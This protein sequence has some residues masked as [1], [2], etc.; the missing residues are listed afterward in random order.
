MSRG[1]LIVL[2]GIDGAGKS[3]LQQVLAKRLRREGHQVLLTR[4][5]ADRELGRKAQEVG[6]SDATAGAILFTLDRAIA[7]PRIEAALERGRFVLQDRSFYSTLAYQ[8]S[9]LPK[10]DL[11]WLRALQRSAAA[12]PDHVLLLDLEPKVALSRL[13]ARGR[14]LAPFERARVLARVR[15]AYLA[16]ATEPGWTVLR[17]DLPLEDLVEEAVRSI[18]RLLRP[19]P[20]TGRR[21]FDPGRETR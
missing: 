5:P 1:R 16:L 9:A 21:S 11:R 17:A 20:R 19:R 12:R 18:A 8:G 6:A 14:A 3:T 2:E 7:K 13:V 15:Q 10:R 4:E